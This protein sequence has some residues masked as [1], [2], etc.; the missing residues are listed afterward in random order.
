MCDKMGA[1]IKRFQKLIDNSGKTRPTIAKELGCDTSTITKHYN[2]DRGITTDYLIKYA[3]YFNVSADYLLGLSNA[4][5]INPEMQAASKYTG[6]NDESIQALRLDT[7]EEIRKILNFFLSDT[8]YAIFYDLC[9]SMVSMPF[10]YKFLAGYREH[11][12]VESQKHNL[13]KEK[14][15]ELSDDIEEYLQNQELL[16]LCSFRVNR[17][18]ENL[19]TLYCGGSFERYN[20]AGS[21]LIFSKY[22]FEHDVAERRYWQDIRERQEN[23]EEIP[24]LAIG[25]DIDFE[26]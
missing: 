6:L 22:Q 20:N 10:Y 23:G 21:Q 8:G 11:I 12:T 25:T 3:K 15:N 4:K 5:S 9:V 24:P 1:N 2:G 13:S 7:S 26:E 14:Q 17:A 16:D 18:L 19:K